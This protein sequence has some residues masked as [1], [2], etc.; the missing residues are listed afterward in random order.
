MAFIQI[1]RMVLYKRKHSLEE[2]KLLVMPCRPCPRHQF[3]LQ[4]LQDKHQ[5]QIF[6]KGKMH[7]N[8]PSQVYQRY[9]CSKL[10]WKDTLSTAQPRLGQPSMEPSAPSSTMPMKKKINRKQKPGTIHKNR[11]STAEP[12]WVFGLAT[13]FSFLSLSLSLVSLPL[14]FYHNL[15]SIPFY[16]PTFKLYII[17]I[18]FFVKGSGVL[19]HPLLLCLLPTSPHP[20]SLTVPNDD[21][22]GS[23]LVNYFPLFIVIYYLPVKTVRLSFKVSK[24][25]A[26]FGSIYH[27]LLSSPDQRNRGTS[28]S[29]IRKSCQPYASK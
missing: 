14:P 13:L 1:K 29:I 25:G 27:G 12:F 3:F 8:V 26:I 2:E 5:Q 7:P 4:A 28:L 22:N 21:K 16:I 19:I 24:S 10:E 23:S 11:E 15:S 6:S 20:P 17:I 18:P 9:T